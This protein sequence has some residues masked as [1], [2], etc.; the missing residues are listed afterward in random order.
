M[1]KY[2]FL[3]YYINHKVSKYILQINSFKAVDILDRNGLF[4][5]ELF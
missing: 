3:S 4:L 5:S 2:V 1:K